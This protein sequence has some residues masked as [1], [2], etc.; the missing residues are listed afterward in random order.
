MTRRKRIPEEVNAPGNAGRLHR[1]RS[2]KGSKFA[3][4]REIADVWFTVDCRRMKKL[5]NAA[6]KFNDEISNEI[7]K[8]AD[9]AAKNWS[10]IDWGKAEAF[11]NRLQIRI[12]KATQNRKTNLA[13]R[14][15][16][17][18]T[19]SF[20][21]KAIAIKTIT[22][23]KGKNTPGIDGITWK[24]AAEK[25]NAISQL[26]SA[27]YQSQ[28]LRRVYI[29]KF[30][31]KEKRPL[32]IPTM[33][34][35]SMQMLYKLALDPI[36]ET[37]ADT[38]SFGFRKF[39]GTHDAME[40]AFTLLSR[41]YSPQWVLE[42]DI[43]GCFDNIS[44]QWLMENVQM[45]KNILQ[46]FLKAGFIYQKELFPTINGTPQ[47]GTIS[48]TLANITLD[49]IGQ[50]LS[51]KFWRN[52]KGTYDIRNNRLK[53]H[54]VRFADDFIVTA[55]TREAAIEAQTIID[56]FLQKRGLRLS[57][58]KTAITHIS[59]GFEFLGWHF[60]KYGSKL[61]IQP[62]KKS[63]MKITTNVSKVISQYRTS[64]Q[65]AL[66]LKLNPML[67]GWANYHQ[68]VCSSRVFKKLDH[69]LWNMLWHW[70]KRRHPKKSHHWIR[71][72]YWST[73]GLR[74][75]V[76]ADEE[77]ELICVSSTPIV[78]HRKI[79]LS[80]NP[81]LDADYYENIKKIQKQRRRV[82][83][84]GLAACLPGQVSNV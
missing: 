14:L 24:S 6:I 50:A 58:T 81:F 30:G 84:Y 53:V 56:C 22:T 61:I 64:T 67:S 4:Y 5:M 60:Q 65:K 32:S 1:V 57:E 17:L 66:I 27:K 8:P 7:E 43:K 34:D 72:R 68:A 38:S 77:C 42:G 11:V 40:Y 20:Y 83:K 35:R 25:I 69:I 18:L 16:Y 45:D 33:K 54:F 44:H 41:R 48:P 71:K 36:A 47:G 55:E 2:D 51:D 46:A 70:A 49:G 13:K 26:D 82:A 12:A 63:I 59:D 9:E 52:Q 78:R 79:K 3:L 29:E 75:W 15:G 31:K 80:M 28:P 39:R 37:L 76:F 23:N 62:S 21:A 19:H 74:N 73:K 10:D